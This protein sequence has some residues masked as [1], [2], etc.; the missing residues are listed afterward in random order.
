MVLRHLVR[1]RGVDCGHA[2]AEA[3]AAGEQTIGSL[4]ALRRLLAHRTGDGVLD[5]EALRA[6]FGAYLGDVERIVA[7]VDALGA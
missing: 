5:P 2:Y 7:A 3:L 4:P 6:E 1:L